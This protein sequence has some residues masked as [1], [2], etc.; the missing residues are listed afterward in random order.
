MVLKDIGYGSV[1]WMYLAQ[2]RG[3]WQALVSTVMNLQ[4]LVPRSRLYLRIGV[5]SLYDYKG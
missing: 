2:D 1:E 4:I 5:Q 3:R